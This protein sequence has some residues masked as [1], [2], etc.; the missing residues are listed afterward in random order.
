MSPP[1]SS[2]S[3][4]DTDRRDFA[5]SS[6]AL[7]DGASPLRIEASH[8]KT[9]RAA[10]S[11]ARLGEYYRFTAKPPRTQR[12]TT[13]TAFTTENPEPTEY[14][15]TGGARQAAQRITEPRAIRRSRTPPR[16]CFRRSWNLAS[17]HKPLGG[18]AETTRGSRR[19][20][21]GAIQAA[22]PKT[23]ICRRWSGFPARDIRRRTG[24]GSSA[25]APC[26][27][28]RRRTSGRA[29]SRWACG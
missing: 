28:T 4:S 15:E 23:S 9:P 25:P 20:F 21:P 27:T 29:M 6:S 5:G 8:A 24:P 7:G 18:S 17:R 19:N 1:R 22:G 11:L 14:G 26:R 12:T 2:P 10:R 3:G 13:A 16:R